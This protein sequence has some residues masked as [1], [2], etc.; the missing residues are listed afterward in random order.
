MGCC[1]HPGQTQPTHA[2]GP[3]PIGPGSLDMTLALSLGIW[4]GV[5]VIMP[6]RFS[7]TTTL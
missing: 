1:R 7:L 4:G 5:G 3:R 2:D 6:F